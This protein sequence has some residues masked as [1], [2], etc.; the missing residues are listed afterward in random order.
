MEDTI[1]DIDTFAGWAT[2]V[3]GLGLQ[4]I[5]LDETPNHFTAERAEYLLAL[6]KYIKAAAAFGANRLVSPF[7]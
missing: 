1:E 6:K 2:E 5:F 7:A 4:G 3:S